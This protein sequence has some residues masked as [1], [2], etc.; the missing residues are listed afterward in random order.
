MAY[1]LG[2]VAAAATFGLIVFLSAWTLHYW[3]AWVL[4]A[5]TF[6]GY[7][8]GIL[9]SIARREPAPLRGS[10]E[11]GPSRP[12]PS[13]EPRVKI[14]T[15]RRFVLYPVWLCFPA[16]LIVPGLDHRFGWSS[17]P[18]S[19]SLAAD[20][21]FAAGLLLT[22]RVRVAILRRFDASTE[23]AQDR[24]MISTGPFAV[25]RHP[26]IAGLLL[27]QGAMPIA[28]GSWWGL[29]AFAVIMPLAVEWTFYEEKVMGQMS[30]DYSEYTH[31]VEYRLVPHVW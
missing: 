12:E 30:S 18:P 11:Q 14:P 3:Q 31:K 27:Y 6:V 4:L 9:G 20:L 15:S 13:D 26:M 29:V 23:E 25:V 1:S 2:T 16:L 21:A 22:Y 28:L 8:S 17:V 24:R 19:I 5:S 10:R 7:G